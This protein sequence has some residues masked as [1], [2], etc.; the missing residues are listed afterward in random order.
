MVCVSGVCVCRGSSCVGRLFVCR[1]IYVEHMAPFVWL[2]C[3]CCCCCSFLYFGSH[4]CFICFVLFLSFFGFPL[5]PPPLHFYFS[6]LLSLL[7]APPPLLLGIFRQLFCACTAPWLPAK[8]FCSRSLSWVTA[9][10][11]F[12]FGFLFF[13]VCICCFVSYLLLP[14]I[15][16]S[17]FSVSTFS[18][19][20]PRIQARL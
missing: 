9:G 19:C 18:S 5:H 10:K 16:S 6:L 7:V 17:G 12:G 15:S 20:L 11:F 8:R 14:G 2:C 3:C 4:S 1:S 13:G